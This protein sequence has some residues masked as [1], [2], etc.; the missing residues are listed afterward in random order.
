MPRG[1][2]DRGR[3]RRWRPARPS[4]RAIEVEVDARHAARVD[5]VEVG[6]VDGHVERDAVIADAAFDAQAERADLARLGAVRIAPA[7]RVAVAPRRPSTPSAAQ[8]VD[9]GR[10]ERPDERPDQQAAVGEAR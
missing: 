6:Q 7:A 1:A 5:Q 10:L 8:V 4:S 2:L 9:E 3:G